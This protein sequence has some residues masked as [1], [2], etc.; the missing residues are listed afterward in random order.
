MQT[1]L[2]VK[3]LF[4]TTT[5]AAAGALAAA[6]GSGPAPATL[7]PVK[8]PTTAPALPTQAPIQP[9]AVKP[10]P[11]IAPTK[12]APT[13]APTH[14]LPT[15]APTA[16]PTTAPVQPTPTAAVKLPLGKAQVAGSL[17]I[18]PN[19]IQ[20]LT[21]SGTDKPKAGDAYLFV[22]VSLVNTGKTDSIE[23]DPVQIFLMG[24]DGKPIAFVALKSAAT[25]LKKQTLKPGAK[26][27]GVVVYE[28][29][30]SQEKAPWT[31]Q[32]KG[33]GSTAL[34]WSLAG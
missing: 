9:T 23:F 26:V 18:L 2:Y 29:A 34:A 3:K 4:L 30:A 27:D 20:W 5:L 22:S 16:A 17:S 19:R 12:A 24:P 7:A 14:A 21:A 10:L 33:L 6:C 8:H 28:V 11:T 25:E 1:Q 31:L 32:Y 15:A 13:S